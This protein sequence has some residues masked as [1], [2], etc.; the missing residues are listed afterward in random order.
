MAIELESQTGI[1]TAL[2]ALLFYNPETGELV[3]LERPR[4][5]FS[6]ERH[7]KR[8]NT[9][10]AGQPAFTTL[11]CGYRQG[12][13]FN[14]LYSAHR[15]AWGLVHG[16]WPDGDVDHINGAGDDNRLVNLR[17]V[18]HAENC[19]NQK[20]QS[21]NTSGV[22]GVN[23]DKRW[24][25]WRAEITVDG[26]TRN[27]GRFANKPDAIAARKLAEREHGFH[28]NHGRIAQYQA[29]GGDFVEVWA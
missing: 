2:D 7:W 11:A 10:F 28:K 21:A 8:W 24:N 14:K 20:R 18:S 4:E 17:A 1:Y 26:R 5:L 16:V 25:K 29:S 13:I 12:R 22:T 9:K 23:W 15:V 19:R 3:W 27:L 6:A